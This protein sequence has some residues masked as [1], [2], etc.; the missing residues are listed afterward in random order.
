MLR[1]RGNLVVYALIVILAV[2]SLLILFRLRERF[3]TNLTD[4][5]ND[6]QRVFSSRTLLKTPSDH[7]VVFAEI[8][9]EAA[10][11]ENRGDFGTIWISKSF[12]EIERV[13]Y[14]FYYPS[15]KTAG[16][17]EVRASAKATL[18]RQGLFERM[19][20]R[21]SLI[22]RPLLSDGVRL[23]TLFVQVNEAALRTVST[24]I[25][26]L[27]VM[28]GTSLAFLA[29]QFRKQEKVLS[30]T[31]IELEEKRRE[32]VRLERLALAG[33]LSANILHDLK[34]PVL[35]IRNEADEALNPLEPD[36]R[37]QAP[38]GI[39]A[40]IR[41]QADFFLT[42]L[43]DAGFDRF[44]RAQ[45]EQ[46]YVDLNALLDRS[47]ALVR[48][49][50]RNIIVTRTYAPALLPVLAAPVRIIQVFSNVIL[51]AYQAMSGRGQLSVETK[52]GVG[53]V[54]VEIVDD[55]PGMSDDLMTHIFE[56]FYTTKAPEHGTGLG[57]YIV[58]DIVRDLGGSIEVKSVPGRT[59]FLIRLPAEE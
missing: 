5:V 31:T 28:L 35:N 37:S 36:T 57:L 1:G 44:V 40:R 56:P 15:L 7:K 22:E 34:K 50:Q 2:L 17:P 6:L 8:E 29:T 39:F 11:Y 24:V 26:A 9:A 59:A 51:N 52:Q 49:E 20:S 45:E 58:A 13:V 4:R 47:L 43:K 32:L 25:W 10:K 3:E 30:A 23:G 42:I 46:E 16:L 14:P 21:N 19:V 55:G 12:G 48:Y 53:A 27:G 38:S 18:V 33:Q 41:E 54:I